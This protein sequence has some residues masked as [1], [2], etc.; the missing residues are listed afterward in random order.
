MSCM[1]IKLYIILLN[2]LKWLV[3]RV[4]WQL[5][6]WLW[7]RSQI[8]K[9]NKT[10]QEEKNV[11]QSVGRYFFSRNKEWVSSSKTKTKVESKKNINLNEILFFFVMDVSKYYKSVSQARLYALV[12]K[13]SFKCLRYSIT[14]LSYIFIDF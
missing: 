14:S 3:C 12:M 7:N 2:C 1:T 6:F 13:R 11:V 9:R 8:L 10:K 5:Y 4:A